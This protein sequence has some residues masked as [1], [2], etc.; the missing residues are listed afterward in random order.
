[1]KSVGAKS[2][3]TDSSALSTCDKSTDDLSSMASTVSSTLTD[4]IGVLTDGAD[5]ERRA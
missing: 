3:S 4:A 2:L 1:M 5:G